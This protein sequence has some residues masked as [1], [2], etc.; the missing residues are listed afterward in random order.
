VLPFGAL[1]PEEPWPRRWVHRR[2]LFAG[3]ALLV[4][5]VAGGIVAAV[6]LAA[7]GGEKAQPVRAAPSVLP[8]Q[9][10]EAEPGELAV[11]LD[12]NAPTGGVEIDHYDIYRNGSLLVTL[13]DVGST[14]V[15]DEV[16][17][18]KEYTYEIEARGKVDGKEMTSER[19][20]ALVTTSVPPLKRARVEGDFSVTVKTLSQSGYDKYEDPTYGWHMRAK[21]RTGPCEVVLG[22]LHEKVIRTILKQ[23]GARYSG[24][25]SGF[26]FDFCGNTRGTSSVRIQLKVANAKAIEGKWLATK[27][28]GTVNKSS[29][30]QLGCVSSRASQAVTAKLVR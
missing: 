14:Y 4:A 23:N 5:L 25:Y 2:W 9:S 18:G 8:P 17:P 16:R 29:G 27:L 26:F 7:G 24:S 6:L 19:V 3:L 1:H 10:F 20:S 13:S 12:W 21:C 15:D 30:A 22:D 28:V 11:T